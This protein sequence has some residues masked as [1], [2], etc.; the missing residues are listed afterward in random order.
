MVIVAFMLRINRIGISIDGIAPPGKPIGALFQETWL[1]PWTAV[2]EVEVSRVGSNVQGGR[3]RLRVRISSEAHPMD[4]YITSSAAH[5]MFG[6]HQQADRFLDMLARI[7]RAIEEKGRP[8]SREEAT[9][10]L[11]I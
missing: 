4:W 6:D 10:V 5:R 1:L 2:N 9:R 3:Q 8:L 7:G 11:A